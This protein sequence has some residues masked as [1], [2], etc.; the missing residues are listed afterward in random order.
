MSEEST[1]TDPVDMPM[2][3]Y[4]ELVQLRAERDRWR[5]EA[6]VSHDVASRFRPIPAGGSSVVGP[7]MYRDLCGLLLDERDRLRV[8]V[9]EIKRHVDGEY[10]GNLAFIRRRIEAL[11][12]F[13]GF[14]GDCGHTKGEG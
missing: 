14:T 5:Q 11:E 12:R 13:Y 10:T 2:N 9:N 6:Q 8:I 1:V 4:A 3:P 7:F